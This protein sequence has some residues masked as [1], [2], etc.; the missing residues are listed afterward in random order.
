[1]RSNLYLLEEFVSFETDGEYQVLDLEF[2]PEYGRGWMEAESGLSGF[3]RLRDDLID[4]D[5]SLLYLARLKAMTI[6]EGLVDGYRSEIF[7][8]EYEPPVPPRH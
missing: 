7:Y 8:S 4:G 6:S 2:K 1:M 5:Y 3:I